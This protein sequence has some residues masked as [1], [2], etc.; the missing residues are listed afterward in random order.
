MSIPG[1]SLVYAADFTAEVGNIQRFAYAK[2]ICSLAGTAPKKAQSGQM[3]SNHLPTSHKGKALLRMTLNQ[4]ALSLNTHCPEYTRYYGEKHAHYQDAPGKAR[5]AT[6][7]KFVRLAFALMKEELL[8]TPNT[9][10]PLTPKREDK[11]HLWEKI[12]NKLA[13][14]LPEE[15][16]ENSY[17]HKLQRQLEE[18]DDLTNEPAQQEGDTPLQDKKGYSHS[19]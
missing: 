8:Y 10:N 13:P 3:D 18:N 17:L 9:R 12:Q 2:Q 19:L 5:T 1:I 6:A 15:I 16:P 7:N 14:Y 11:H 4:L